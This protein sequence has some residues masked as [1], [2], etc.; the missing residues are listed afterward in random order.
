[1]NSNTRVQLTSSR[2]GGHL[3]STG[4]KPAYPFQPLM[5]LHNPRNIDATVLREREGVQRVD[6]K[7]MLS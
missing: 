6:G 7:S 4:S 3:G 5:A 2:A 1:M